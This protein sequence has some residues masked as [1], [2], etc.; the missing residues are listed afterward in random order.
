MVCS[1]DDF[2]GYELIVLPEFIAVHQE[3]FCSARNRA[4][5]FE[6][7]LSPVFP[8]G[9]L[10]VG[11][12]LIQGIVCIWSIARSGIPQDDVPSGCVI[13]IV[14]SCRYVGGG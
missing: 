3:N 5:C 7:V 11:V 10:A 4:F 13:E 8:P 12:L 1:K 9:D 2:L 6:P 14:F